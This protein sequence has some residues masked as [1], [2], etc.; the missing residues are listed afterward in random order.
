MEEILKLIDETTEPS[1]MGPG[2]ALEFL[3]RLSSN[4]ESRIDGIKDDMR[5]AGGDD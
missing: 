5:S 2:A 4:I 1:R 3:E